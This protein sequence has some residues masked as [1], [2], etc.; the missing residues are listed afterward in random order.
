MCSAGACP[1]LARSGWHGEQS[2]SLL[3][4]TPA[5]V[6]SI[7]RPCSQVRSRYLAASHAGTR[8]VEAAMSESA[9]PFAAPAPQG[10]TE[11]SGA[12]D[13]GFSVADGDAD[14]S[15]QGPPATTGGPAG[16]AAEEASSAQATVAQGSAGAEALDADFFSQPAADSFAPAGSAADHEAPAGVCQL[17]ITPRSARQCSRDWAKASTRCCVLRRSACHCAASNLLSHAKAVK[18]YLSARGLFWS[19]HQAPAE[20]SSTT[21]TGTTSNQAHPSDTFKLKIGEFS[22]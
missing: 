18:L 19:S 5:A 20:N 6:A 22:V 11:A 15:S 7:C 2:C 10:S 14:T 16:D 17:L 4:C 8:H 21:S 3:S 9:N 1:P 12:P 13:L